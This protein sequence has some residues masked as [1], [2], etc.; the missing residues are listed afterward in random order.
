MMQRRPATSETTTAM[1]P[2]ELGRAEWAAL[3]DLGVPAILAKIDT[4]AR[5]SALH[6]DQIEIYQTLV[7]PRVRFVV[8]PV[9]GRRDVKRDCD[10]PLI[11]RRW[12]TSSSGRRELRCVVS[13]LVEIGG[14]RWPLEISLTN[15]GRMR[16]RMLLGRRAILDGM[17]V[18]P[19]RTCRQIPIGYG[20]YGEASITKLSRPMKS[21]EADTPRRLRIGLIGEGP[22]GTA[23]QALADAA[24]ARG[25]VV[26]RIDVHSCRLLKTEGR[27]RIE[28][29]GRI[30]SQMDAVIAMGTPGMGS[31]LPSVVRHAELGGA[32]ALNGSGALTGL[33]DFTRAIQT[34]WHAQIPTTLGI[35][36]ASTSR[37]DTFCAGARRAKKVSGLVVDGKIVASG[38]LEDASAEPAAKPGFAKLPL[39]A[40]ER[41]LM[42]RTARALELG[43]VRIDLVRLKNRKL[44]VIGIDAS[45]SL[46]VFAKFTKSNSAFAI[47]TALERRVERKI[48]AARAS[49]AAR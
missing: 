15:R 21:T 40:N 2:F 31:F 22:L 30:I 36:T 28:S 19:R 29:G 3:P 27:L 25:H 23:W 11:A 6:A 47:V 16:Y 33:L 46:M 12:I 38:L 32:A 18:L 14:R 37:T 39:E 42:I 8:H 26:E 41:R 49:H 17:V 13:T 20:V 48:Q 4:G 44:A 9:T 34:L 24:L 45:P 10:A 1:A 43:A 35:L 7:G 5:T